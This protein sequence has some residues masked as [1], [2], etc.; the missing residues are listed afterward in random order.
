MVRYR[1]RWLGQIVRTLYIFI[2]GCFGVCGGNALNRPIVAS[3]YLFLHCAP[4][5]TSSIMVRTESTRCTQNL[6]RLVRSVAE[7]S[8]SGASLQSKFTRT[9]KTED[10]KDFA[11]WPVPLMESSLAASQALHRAPSW[12]FV[13]HEPWPMKLL[14][15]GNANV[16]CR[17]INCCHFIIF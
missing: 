17:K 9:S 14:F 1:V 8:P 16:F 4:S 15:D 6:T 11:F 5:N 12:T 7:F 3:I 2:Q 13:Q 10:Q